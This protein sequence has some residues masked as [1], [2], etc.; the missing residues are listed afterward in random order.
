MR[1]ESI[2][3]QQNGA[4]DFAAAVKRIDFTVIL[5]AI[6]VILTIALFIRAYHLNNSN[7]PN[8]PIKGQQYGQT[9]KPFVKD[10]K[11]DDQD[12]DINSAIRLSDADISSFINKQLGDT[13]PIT[14]ISVEF[15]KDQT[16]TLSGNMNKKRLVAYI[17]DNEIKLSAAISGALF[18]IPDSLETKIVF[19]IEEDGEDGMLKL[20][21]DEMTLG[22]QK[23]PDQIMNFPIFMQVQEILN[24]AISESRILFDKI[25][26]YDGAIELTI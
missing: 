23:L 20:T 8:N 1:Q 13:F 19:G 16:M 9:Q 7:G 5:L 26:I 2:N 24:R 12:T 3:K 10:Q 21:I 15:S 17:Q 18:L 6:A 22:N 14:D 25:E 11:K 4:G